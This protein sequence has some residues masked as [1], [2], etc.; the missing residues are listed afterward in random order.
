[1][2][3]V[4]KCP[5]CGRG[6]VI[7]KRVTEVMSGGQHTAFIKVSAGVCLYCGERIYLPE[8]IRNFKDIETRLEQHELS[9]FQ[10]VGQ[11]FQVNI[12]AF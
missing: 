11:S 1:M 5:L 3:Y 9:G 6:E 2:I 4:K 8:T 12:S 10:S 7:E